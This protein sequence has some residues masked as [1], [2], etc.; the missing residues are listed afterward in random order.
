MGGIWL[1]GSTTEE[2]LGALADYRFNMSLK[3]DASA[4]NANVVWDESGTRC[5]KW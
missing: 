2:D 1:D 5:G 4:Q 3:Y